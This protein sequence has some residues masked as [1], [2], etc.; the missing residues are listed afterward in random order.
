MVQSFFCW[1]CRL[2]MLRGMICCIRHKPIQ[3]D[4]CWLVMLWVM[5]RWQVISA[6]LRTDKAICPMFLSHCAIVRQALWLYVGV[7]RSP[8]PLY[9]ARRTRCMTAVAPVVWRPPYALLTAA[10]P[11]TF[12][13]KERWFVMYCRYLTV[14]NAVPWRRNVWYSSFY[15]GNAISVNILLSK[16]TGQS[17]WLFNSFL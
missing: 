13:C 2:V 7:R 9:D 11:W 6:L 8:Y 3:A 4:C 17:L 14:V 12:C 1:G 15:A 5:I 10:E 16:K